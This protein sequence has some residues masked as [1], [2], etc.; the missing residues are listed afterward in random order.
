MI[1]YLSINDVEIRKEI[2]PGKG[3]GIKV[4]LF[5]GTEDQIERRKFTDIRNGNF[6]KLIAKDYDELI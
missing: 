2:S 4:E 5:Y 6:G 1:E 3:T